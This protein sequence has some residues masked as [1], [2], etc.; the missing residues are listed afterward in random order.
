MEFYLDAYNIIDEAEKDLEVFQNKNY[1]IINLN[2]LVKKFYEKSW[3]S[4]E[5]NNENADHFLNEQQ[6]LKDTPPMILKQ[7]IMLQK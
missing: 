2:K 7:E 6:R 5:K 1:Y 3:E 4:G